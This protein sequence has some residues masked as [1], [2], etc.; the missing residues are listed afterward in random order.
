[1]LMRSDHI[2][3]KKEDKSRLNGYLTTESAFVFSM[4]I[5]LYFLIIMAALLL[6]ARCLTSQNDYIIALRGARFTDAGEAY[7]EVIY[8]DEKF[9]A[10]SYA[11]ERLNRVGQTYPVYRQE[12]SAVRIDPSSVTVSTR[13]GSRIGTNE[14][15][16]HLSVNNPIGKVKA[17]RGG[18]ME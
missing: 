6:F 10:V 8:G 13:A 2:K 1:M 15:V 3:C 14:C 4:C 7:G 9:D 11:E 12:S 5:M 17:E 16:K 18:G